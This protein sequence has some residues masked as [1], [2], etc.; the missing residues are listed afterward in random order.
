[1]IQTVRYAARPDGTFAG[2]YVDA[3]MPDGCTDTGIA[4]VDGRQ[5][6]N[7]SAWGDPAPLAEDLEAH[8]A[9]IRYDREV[10]G[11]TVGSMEISTDRDSQAK[12]L[13]ARVA[14]MTDPGFATTWK[15]ANGFFPLDAAGIVGM[16]DAALAHVN[17]CFAAEASVSALI[18]EE[19][20]VDLAGV[21]AAFI[22][23]L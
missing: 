17:T 16:S 7:G 3:L 1:M 9:S 12:I 4:P 10:A 13:A 6:W 19:G 15:A 5:I 20:V 2:T 8:L 11:V 23:A 14:A 22:A 18:D 21:E